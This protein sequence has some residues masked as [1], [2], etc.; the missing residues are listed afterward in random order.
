[1]NFPEHRVVCGDARLLARNFEPTAPT[2]VITDPVWPN[3]SKKFFPGVNAFE[4]LHDVLEQ[5][6]GKASHVVVQVGC[7]TDPRF[8]KAVPDHWPF[9]RTCSLR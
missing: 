4:L 1:M 6:I 5:L 9:W 8:L 7:T 3:R 2:V